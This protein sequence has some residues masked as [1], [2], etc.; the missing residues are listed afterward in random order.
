[1]FIIGTLSSGVQLVE[2]R[3]SRPP[4]DTGG[5]RQ[6]KISGFRLRLNGIEP[7]TLVNIGV[8]TQFY[9]EQFDSTDAPRGPPDSGSDYQRR[10]TELTEPAQVLTDPRSGFHSKVHRHEEAVI[11][12]A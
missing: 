5:G 3:R 7:V 6:L 10:I 8:I 4:A 9:G 1:M 12:F 11:G 2:P